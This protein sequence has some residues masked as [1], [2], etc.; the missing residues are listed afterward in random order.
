MHSEWFIHK[1]LVALPKLDSINFVGSGFVIICV[2]IF[3]MSFSGLICY[4][5][6]EALQI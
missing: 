6:Q 1:I 5:K 3:G 2:N 4:S